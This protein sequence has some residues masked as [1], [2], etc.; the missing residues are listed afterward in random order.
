MI[1]MSILLV[2]SLFAGTG[3][4]TQMRAKIAATS[5]E[6]LAVIEEAKRKAPE[7]HSSR[8]A[9][10][11]GDAVDDCI[12]ARGNTHID[13]IGWSA[14]KNPQGRWTISFYFKDAR[15]KYLE[16]TWEYN[17]DTGVLFPAE[18]TNATKFWVKRSANQR[19]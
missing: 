2:V 16:A 17:Q 1:K 11:L 8:S 18:F 6:G 19:P 5:P 7:I 15:R 4:E 10:R 13:P 12:N 14:V 3:Q 9:K